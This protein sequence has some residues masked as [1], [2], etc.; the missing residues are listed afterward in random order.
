MGIASFLI[1][2][3]KGGGRRGGAYKLKKCRDSD[4]FLGG[5]L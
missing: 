5:G 2:V 4:P 1:L 3:L